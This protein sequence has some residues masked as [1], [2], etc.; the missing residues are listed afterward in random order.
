MAK[1]KKP[2]AI[3]T[4]TFYLTTTEMEKMLRVCSF[5]LLKV[6]AYYK[7]TKLKEGIHWVRNTDYYNGLQLLW[8]KAGVEF[9]KDYFEKHPEKPRS[10]QPGND[11]VQNR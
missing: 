7:N 10:K 4:K 8:S 2:K 9:M 11:S 6:K 3:D 1:T 5:R